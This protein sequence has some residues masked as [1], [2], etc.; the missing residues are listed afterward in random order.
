MSSEDGITMRLI[1]GP[2]VAARRAKEARMNPERAKKKQTARE[3][4]L[5]RLAIVI[6]AEAWRSNH[7]RAWLNTT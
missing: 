6:G 2:V 3:P 1:Q 4:L 7:T 5:K